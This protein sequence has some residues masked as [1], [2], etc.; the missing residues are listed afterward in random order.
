LIDQICVKVRTEV[1]G[2][3]VCIAIEGVRRP[4]DIV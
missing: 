1:G 3:N 2:V 4:H